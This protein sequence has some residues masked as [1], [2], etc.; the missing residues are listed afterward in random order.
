MVGFGVAGY[1]GIIERGI[2]QQRG[3]KPMTTNHNN[4]NPMTE[5]PLE[6]AL[7]V[8][9][10]GTLP[11]VISYTDKG[12]TYRP[13]NTF[14]V[15]ERNTNNAVAVSRPMTSLLLPAVQA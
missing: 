5:T 4:T 12:A 2:E 3:A 1:T 9:A 7:D 11:P 15:A 10:G 14:R 8:I 6:S 13:V